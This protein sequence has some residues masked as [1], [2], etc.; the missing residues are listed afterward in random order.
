MHSP[1]SKKVTT[2]VGRI[3]VANLSERCSAMEITSPTKIY[4]CPFTQLRISIV[5]IGHPEGYPYVIETDGNA[6][7]RDEYVKAHI[8]PEMSQLKQTPNSL[9][10]LYW[11]LSIQ[12]PTNR[13]HFEKVMYWQSSYVASFDGIG[14][15]EIEDWISPVTA[16]VFRLRAARPIQIAKNER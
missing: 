3:Q 4:Q 14:F 9:A 13:R 7:L 12:L 2:A 16:N 11:K 1:G 10:D 8:T 15:P 5:E 6:T